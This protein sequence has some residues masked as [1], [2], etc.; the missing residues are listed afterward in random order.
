M[1]TTIYF[2]P[3]L[4]SHNVKKSVMQT[5]EASNCI[6]FSQ[7][8]QIFEVCQPLITNASG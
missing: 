2:S 1:P 4:Q 8:V 5:V 3:A 6:T 7:Q